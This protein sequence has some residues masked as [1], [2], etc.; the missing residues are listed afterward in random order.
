MRT[1]GTKGAGAGKESL[2]PRIK[3]CAR[4]KAVRIAYRYCAAEPPS[5][6]QIISWRTEERGV[7]F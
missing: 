2:R 5:A 4:H 1:G 6:R 3:I 7:P